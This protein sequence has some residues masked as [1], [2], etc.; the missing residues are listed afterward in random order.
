MARF[1]RGCLDAA[2]RSGLATS[3]HR[4][5]H[6]QR[7]GRGLDADNASRLYVTGC[8]LPACQ[9]VMHRLPAQQRTARGA[10]ARRMAILLR[11]HDRLRAV[12]FRLIRYVPRANGIIT[13]R[14]LRRGHGGHFVPRAALFPSCLAVRAIASWFELPPCLPAMMAAAS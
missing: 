9:A 5:P 8:V 11:D 13:A 12:Y 6:L 10:A 7:H 1:L 4:H 14:S 2:V 3:F